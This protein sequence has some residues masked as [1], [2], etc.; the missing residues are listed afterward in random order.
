MRFSAFQCDRC[1]KVVE[2]KDVKGGLSLK[3]E[4]IPAERNI[5]RQIDLC[6]LC[7]KAF[8]TWLVNHYSVEEALEAIGENE[9]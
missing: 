9:K 7:R 3:S 8:E 4:P 1:K 2:D 6:A 5:A